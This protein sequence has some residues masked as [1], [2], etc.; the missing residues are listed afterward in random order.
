MPGR[1]QMGIAAQS[2]VIGGNV[3]V[4]LEDSLWI[5]P[6]QLAGTNGAQV[7]K[8]RRII[9]DLGCALATPDDARRTLALKGQTNVAF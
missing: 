6:G 9:A 7:T 4:G 5:G 2:V 8:V 3:R 1:S